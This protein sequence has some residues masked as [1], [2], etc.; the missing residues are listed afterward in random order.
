MSVSV[1]VKILDPRIE[2]EFGLPGYAT[3]GAAGMDLRAC[4]HDPLTLLSGQTELI[5]TGVA[6]YI[7]N[8]RIAAVL[9]PRSGM[10]HKHGIVLGNLT[11]LIDSDYQGQLFVSCWNRGREE[12]TIAPGDRIAQMMFVPVIQVGFEVVSEFRAS[13]RA[14]SGFGST[15]KR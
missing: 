7:G 12:F 4:V 9:I 6:M 8:P 15:G 2:S 10:G 3:E 1:Q 13:D 11:G 14:A 5:P